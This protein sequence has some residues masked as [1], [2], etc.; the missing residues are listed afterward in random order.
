MYVCMYVCLKALTRE[1]LCACVRVC[2]IVRLCTCVCA[3]AHAVVERSR[4]QERCESLVRQR[5]MDIFSLING[6][7]DHIPPVTY[8]FEV[9]VCVGGW[10]AWPH[11]G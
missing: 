9:R 6:S 5:L 1:R 3:R 10:V 2:E 4:V 8:Q 7:M 11:C